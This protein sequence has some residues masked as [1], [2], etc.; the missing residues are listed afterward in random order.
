MTI[1]T[2]VFANAAGC[3]RA[4]VD[5]ES[6]AYAELVVMMLSTMR[7]IYQVVVRSFPCFECSDMYSESVEE[8]AEYGE[9]CRRVFDM[10]LGHPELVSHPRMSDAIAWGRREW[11]V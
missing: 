1:A 5:A 11:N 8:K 4:K 6:Q 3:F 9:F 10:L 2:A 7:D